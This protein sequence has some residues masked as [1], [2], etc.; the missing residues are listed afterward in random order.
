MN[1]VLRLEKEGKVKQSI[2][3]SFEMQSWREKKLR[4]MNPGFRIH[5][6][7]FLLQRK[8]FGDLSKG[9]W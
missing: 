3:K 7:F 2:W 1:W 9:K 6:H 4:K 5:P 8:M